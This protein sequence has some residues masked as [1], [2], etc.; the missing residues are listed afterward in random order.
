M[1]CGGGGQPACLLLSTFT[2]MRPVSEHVSV[3][4][5]PNSEERL[6]RKELCIGKKEQSYLLVL[7]NQILHSEIQKGDVYSPDLRKEQLKR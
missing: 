5:P 4:Y 1:T 7:S 2:N 3:C 6:F